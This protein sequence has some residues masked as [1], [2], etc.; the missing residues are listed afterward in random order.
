VNFTQASRRPR[1]ICPVSGPSL[2]VTSTTHRLDAATASLVLDTFPRCG[3]KYISQ[4]LDIVFGRANRS[5]ASQSEVSIR[6]RTHIKAYLQGSLSLFGGALYENRA[7][8]GSQGKDAG[9]DAPLRGL[10]PS[11]GCLQARYLQERK[12]I[13]GARRLAAVLLGDSRFSFGIDVLRIVTSVAIAVRLKSVGSRQPSHTGNTQASARDS[14]RKIVSTVFSS[15]GASRRE[16]T[17]A[18]VPQN[19]LPV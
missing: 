13:F 1:A 10:T 2:G 17:P 3:D 11:A 16:T 8:S 9:R 18:G 5:P 19:Y 4:T 12:T 7:R 14:V 15:V 6:S